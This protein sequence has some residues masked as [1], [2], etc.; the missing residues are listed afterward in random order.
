MRRYIQRLPVT[1]QEVSTRQLLQE[2]VQHYEQIAS[3]LINDESSVIHNENNHHNHYNN[4]NNN[5]HPLSPGATSYMLEDPSVIAARPAVSTLTSSH[6]DF[7]QSP[8]SVQSDTSVI[9]SR[10]SQANTKLMQAIDWDEAKQTNAAIAAYMEAAELYLEA[11]KLA[12]GVAGVE[13]IAE[14]IKRRLEQTLDRIEVLKQNKTLPR[15]WKSDAR[16]LPPPPP[17]TSE[18]A[19]SSC[20]SLT[21][22]EI[23]VLKRSS[24]IA[25]GLF[26]PWSDE[27]AENLAASALKPIAL[28]RDPDGFLKLNAK[29]QARFSKWARPAEIV[30][31][32]QQTGRSNNNNNKPIQPVLIKAITPYTI[33]Q[34]CVT[35][36]SFIAGLCICAAFERRFR[37]PLVS[38]LLHPQ[39][40]DGTPF[41]NPEGKYMV[42]LWLNGV[43]RCVTIDD[44]LPI[45]KYGNLLCSQTATS[46]VKNQHGPYMELWVSLIEKAYMKLAG[47][48]DFPGS[49]SGVDLFSLTGWIPERILFA[50]DPTK[51]RDFETPPERA[52]ERIFSASSYGDCLIT[53]STERTPL[54]EELQS[55]GLVSGHAYAVLSVIQTRNGTRLLQLKNPWAHQG[56]NGRFSCHDDESWKDPSFCAEVGYNPQLARQQD[57]GVFWICWDDVMTYFNNFHLSWNPTLFKYRV[58]THGFWPKEQGPMD[59]TFNVGD[60][61]QYILTLSDQALARKATVWILVSRHVTKQEQEGSEVGYL[62]KE[63]ARSLFCFRQHLT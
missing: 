35:D 62:V 27:D 41:L 31:I 45:D 60:N 18:D 39:A 5:N 48:Y 54:N 12:D 38:S 22:E 63:M 52:W 50:H 7:W 15:A 49:N 20:S 26:L 57:D 59:D 47:G 4:N 13:A 16:T 58:V 23:S 53:V 19:V 43:A 3:T 33:R 42:K 9:H 40:K 44:Y 46:A 17:T 37:K 24:L 14:V 29:Q 25:S 51:V 34:Q 11:M 1:E 61:P 8:R 10:S 55:T 30:K 6:G 2:K 36:C 56:W 21:T 28:Y 32:R